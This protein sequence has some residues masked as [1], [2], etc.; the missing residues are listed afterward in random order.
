MRHAASASAALALALLMCTEAAAQVPAAQEP[1]PAVAAASPGLRL[2][3]SG[4]FRW[5]GLKIYDAILWTREAPAE[6]FT[7]PF[8]L[9]LRY[10]RNLKGT[11]IA[12][13]SVEEIESL[14][15]GSAQKRR[16]W[17]VA[18]ARLFPDVAEG[19][20]LTGLHLP[21]QGARFFLDGKPL[22]EIA[23]A[24]FSRAFFSIW[25]DARTSAPDLRAALLGER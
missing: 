8:A 25:L 15:I 19:T 24:E 22:G 23:D 18:M 13:R 2:R 4:S 5:F 9:M 21:G 14:G 17:G 16:D 6:D 12:E 3:G 7:Q 10:A 1:P 20:T 11:A